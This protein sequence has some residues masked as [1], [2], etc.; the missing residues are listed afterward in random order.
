MEYDQQ[1]QDVEDPSDKEGEDKEETC[2][3]HKEGSPSFRNISCFGQNDD[4]ILW[5]LTRDASNKK[6]AN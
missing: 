3:E 4:A 2:G 1:D 5:M 6:Q